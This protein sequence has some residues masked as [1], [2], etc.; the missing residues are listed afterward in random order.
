MTNKTSNRS[1]LLLT[2]LFL[3]L[4]RSV[5]ASP[6]PT[7]SA[8]GPVVSIQQSPNSNSNHAMTASSFSTDDNLPAGCTNTS[9]HGFQWTVSDFHYSSSLTYTTPSHRISGATVRFNLTSNALPELNVYCDAYSSDFSDPFYGQRVYDCTTVVNSTLGASVGG[10]RGR[11]LAEGGQSR[12][13]FRYWKSSQSVEVRQTWECDDLEGPAA[14]M[15]IFSANGTSA[16][17]TP[18]CTFEEHQTP[19]AEW[20]NGDT[21]YWN[22][23]ACTLSEFS[24]APSELQVFA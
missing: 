10:K 16:A 14:N 17:Q 22:V 20:K 19:P 12:T 11:V 5:A 24:F 8:S 4:S 3:L 18:N 2:G 15:A 21:Y 13:Q 23:Q 6:V 9:L 1:G 7:S